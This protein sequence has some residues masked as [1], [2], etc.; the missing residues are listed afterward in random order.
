MEREPFRILVVLLLYTKGRSPVSTVSLLLYMTEHTSSYVTFQ[1]P[2]L[3][4]KFPPAKVTAYEAVRE[5][6]E[7]ENW[8]ERAEVIFKTEHEQLVEVVEG[9]LEELINH[10]PLIAKTVTDP[11]TVGE[12]DRPDSPPSEA[13][14]NNPRTMSEEI[15]IPKKEKKS[16][17]EMT[18]EELAGMDPFSSSSK[19]MTNSPPVKT[20]GKSIYE[21]SDEDLAKMNPFASKNTVQNS[22]PRQAAD[23]NANAMDGET[24]VETKQEAEPAN[25][26]EEEKKD[27]VKSASPPEQ[28][29]EEKKPKKRSPGNK[30]PTKLKGPRKVTK[31]PSPKKEIV[32]TEEAKEDVP[33]DLISGD[34][35]STQDV[36]MNREDM[37]V[38]DQQDLPTNGPVGDDDI[39]VITE[40]EFRPG[41]EVFASDDPAAFDMD[42]LEKMGDSNDFHASA[43]ARQS[44][45]VKFDPLMKDLNGQ[46]Q[47]V[48]LP[49]SSVPPTILE[50]ED[51]LQMQTPPQRRSAAPV[52]KETQPP[53]SQETVSGVDKLL[54]YSPSR[55]ETEAEDKQPETE[56]DGVESQ[57]GSPPFSSSRRSIVQ[58]RR[59]NSASS[60]TACH[61]IEDCAFQ[62]TFPSLVNPLRYSQA[63]LEAA[64]ETKVRI[65]LE[66]AGRESRKKYDDYDKEM[67]DMT[68]QQQS[69]EKTNAEMRA[70]TAEYEKAMQQLM[71]DISQT[72]TSSDDRVQQLQK[73]KDQALEDLSSVENAFS[74]LHKRYE[75]LKATVQ[76]YKKNEDVLKKCVEEHQSQLK[77]QELKYQTLKGHAEDKIKVANEEIDKMK[78]SYGAE[79]SGLQANLKREQLKVASLERTVEE[80]TRENK[81]LTNIC[82]ELISQVGGGG[83]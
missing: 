48:T 4:P 34:I 50:G 16:I 74:D 22:P 76:G 55:D 63:D 23:M 83:H 62:E 30:K 24:K 31:K 17:Y 2:I 36:N 51:L 19:G 44:L 18:D 26:S 69:L 78:K 13:P 46:K 56:V 43:L 58:V 8:T 77:K 14:S 39:P 25:N 60:I 42:F 49:A 67:K 54:S 80:K 12:A 27:E 1:T 10:I 70:L 41:T 61:H 40:D 35:P 38:G 68:T 52:G 33:I 79:I 53:T 20:S 59:S 73:E 37:V 75:K 47:G 45:Y 65:A 5:L 9:F 6:D 7:K 29:T 66:H 71:G 32:E 82:D 64:I 57:E 3:T 72:K 21:L 28:S 11:P 81:E 15:P